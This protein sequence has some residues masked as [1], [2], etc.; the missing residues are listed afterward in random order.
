MFVDSE[1]RLCFA[2]FRWGVA[3][4]KMVDAMVSATEIK[5]V[6]DADTFQGISMTEL[7][8]RNDEML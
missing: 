2:Q 6:K 3:D 4:I 7:H 5:M 1:S 8:E